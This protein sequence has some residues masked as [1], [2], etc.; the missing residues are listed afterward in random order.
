[1]PKDKVWWSGVLA[2][3][4][5]RL[6]YAA[7][8]G[9][10]AQPTSVVV[11]DAATGAVRRRIQVGVN[12]YEIRL[13]PDGRQL[14]ASNWADRSVSVV[15]TTTGEV[16]RTLPVGPNPNDLLVTPDGRLFVVCAGD[17]TIRVFDTRTLQALE[18]LSTALHPRAPEGSTPN[19]LAYDPARKLLFAANADNNDIAV[20]DVKDRA[21][22]EAVGFI[23][24]GWYP[25]ALA[26]A[27]DGAALYVGA[28]K[29]EGG[30]PDLKGPGSPLASKP[31]GDESIKTLQRSSIER[32]PAGRCT[33]S[34]ARRRRSAG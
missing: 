18:T 28:T 14:F 1:M 8:R 15:D 30:H 2:D 31:G 24:T 6:L 16:S 13:S 26:V 5:H 25:S 10:S 11:F 34:E 32:S 19:A 4:R 27:E 20:F 29:G 22:N 33:A 23:P 3:P 21:R 12:P 9:G 17:N 7:N